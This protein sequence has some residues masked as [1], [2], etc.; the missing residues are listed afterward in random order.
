MLQYIQ[1]SEIKE[2]VRVKLY[3]AK[4][5]KSQNKK[6]LGKCEVHIAFSAYYLRMR[7]SKNDSI[8]S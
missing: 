8:R 6:R 3:S 2:K 4:Q 1:S 5:C 7:S